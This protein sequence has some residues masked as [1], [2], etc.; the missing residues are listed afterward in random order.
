MNDTASDGPRA[1][2]FR[3][4][5][6][7]AA[8]FL[9]V[10]LALRTALFVKAHDEAGLS[11]V[12]L[13]LVLGVGLL[14]DVAAFAY[15]AVPVV[16]YL[17]VVPDV[18]WRSRIH[19]WFALALWCAFAFVVCVEATSEWFFWDEFGA[20]FN[21]VAVDY[22]V[23]T[24]EVVGNIRE[25]YPVEW[26]LP[27]LLA[28]AA[29]IVFFARSR[30]V[31]ALK[32]P[33]PRSRRWIHAPVCL[34]V[35]AVAW[36]ALDDRLSHIGANFAENELAMN[37]VYAFGR[38]F[39]NNSL[40]YE[41]FYAQRDRGAVAA[42]M[43][44]LLSRDGGVPRGAAAD[45]V[46]GAGLL[47]RVSHEGGER[48]LNVVLVTVES[49]AAR[50]LVYSGGDHSK[51]GLTPNLDRLAEQSLLFTRMYATGNRTVRGLEALSLSIP[52]TPG[53]ST[54]KRPHNDG[55]FSTGFLFRDR[56]YDAKFIYGGYGYFDNM[57]AFFEGNGFTSVDRTDF[58]ADE[59]PFANIWGVADEG[60][61]LR[62]LREGDA[63]HAAGRPFFFHVM[64]TSNHQPYT[65][66]AGRIDIPSGTGRLGAVKYTDW[67]I[68]KLIDDARKKPWFDD[69]V[70]VIV[71]DHTDNARG[72]TQLP[73]D[74]YHV[75]CIVYAPKIV[76]PGR[77]DG[78]C[79][80]IDVPPTVLGILNFS[81]DSKFFGQDVLR[82][83]PDRALICNYLHVGLYDGRRLVTLGPHRDAACEDIDGK[84]KP[85]RVDPPDASLVFDAI[86]YFQSASDALEHGGYLRVRPSH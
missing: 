26:I 15:A 20:R 42:R 31:S 51:E 78:V 82:N 74:R 55:L 7:A 48:R 59:N 12:R 34:V 67:A 61:F 76:A 17:L 52:P 81:Y 86:A 38:A 40:S 27:L 63:S 24:G 8:A 37:G 45:A 44:E 18:V 85:H 83:P 29:L 33:T 84:W 10:S 6:L 57:S 56:G 4:L 13:P 72:F 62:V 53:Q 19:R 50:Y 35:P 30:L 58:A 2:R 23:Y 36:F 41:Q 60:L 71:A 49:L 46:A 1:T 14:Y 69:T 5:V 22:L 25:T 79:S 21:F 70:F 77:F 32:A 28:P 43:R 3:V 9:V 65:Y 75:P 11:L 68:G 39:W 54:V 64:T 66:P 80:Q 73:V 47:R 16:L